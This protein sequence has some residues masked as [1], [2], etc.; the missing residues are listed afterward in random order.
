MGN[1][2]KKFAIGTYPSRVRFL[3]SQCKMLSSSARQLT[4][5]AVVSTTQ[6]KLDRGYNKVKRLQKCCK[7]FSVLFYT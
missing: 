2:G 6:I 4:K 1:T 7:R 3:P 5:D